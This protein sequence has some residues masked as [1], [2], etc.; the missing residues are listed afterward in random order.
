MSDPD[1]VANLKAEILPGCAD[2]SC[3]EE[4]AASLDPFSRIGTFRLKPRLTPAY[5]SYNGLVR[6]NLNISA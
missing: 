5:L 3:F 6:K 2:Y 1:N 4:T